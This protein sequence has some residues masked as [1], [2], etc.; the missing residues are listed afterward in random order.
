MVTISLNYFS[1]MFMLNLNPL[2]T[3][4][5]NREREGGEE[6]GGEGENPLRLKMFTKV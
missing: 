5:L 4:G 6:G 3:D 2:V 1:Q